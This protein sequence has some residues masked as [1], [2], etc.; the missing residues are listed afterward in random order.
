[1]SNVQG[2]QSHVRGSPFAL[3]NGATAQEALCIV[4]QQ[5]M[6]AP[7]AVH[8]LFLSSGERSSQNHCRV[9]PHSDAASWA[10][11]QLKPAAAPKAKP[12]VLLVLPANC[13][14]LHSS[15]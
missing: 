1:M 9:K 7:A 8:L 11:L 5:G 12:L 13:L 6:Q 3:V 15:R 4:V 14:R 10:V 2:S